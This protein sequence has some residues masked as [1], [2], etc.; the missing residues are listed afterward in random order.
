[1]RVDFSV[2]INPLGMRDSIKQALVQNLEKFSAYPDTKCT[3]LVQGIASF[4]GVREE[5][6]LCSNGAADLIFRL[7]L[8]CKP[9]KSVLAAPAFSEY[10]KALRAVGCEIQYHALCEGNG[11]SLEEDY[12][13]ELTEDVDMVFLCNPN[14]PC[15][16]MIMPA[17]LE[18]IL[19]ICEKK[20]ILAVLDEC[21]MDFVSGSEVY[22][23][24][25]YLVSNKN[26]VVIKAFTKL[27]A[28][29]GLRLGYGLFGDTD[30]L[31]K[32]QDSTQTWSVSVPAQIAGIAALEDSEEYIRQTVEAVAEQR[33]YLQRGLEELG[34]TVYHSQTNFILFKA[35][36]GLY[37]KLLEQ[38][39]L[40][41]SCE[42]FTGLGAEY[43]RIAVRRPDENNALL[44]AVRR[45]K[46]G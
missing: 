35:F 22:S 37:D 23:A 4:E 11:F 28:M 27:F 46:N 5:N 39:F 1:M 6:I 18:K 10:E 33:A 19:K 45:V 30:L 24:K 17:L 32:V 9:K 20:N 25:K 38:G 2:N 13:S 29:A 42:N 41:R 12:L 7:C 34:F 8:A 31:Q 43:F 36:A 26:V 44:C 3:E 40:I 21:F 15:G 16:N 14:N